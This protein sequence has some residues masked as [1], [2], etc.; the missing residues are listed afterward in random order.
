MSLDPFLLP[1]QKIT[2]HR[3]NGRYS[4]IV[5]SE[6]VLGGL[7]YRLNFDPQKKGHHP[8]RREIIDAFIKQLRAIQSHYSKV[9][10]FRFDLSVPEG[11]SVSQSNDLVS[12]LF[13]RLRGR[14]KKKAWNKQPIKKFAYG[15]VRERESAAQ[16]HYHCWIALPHFQVDTAGFRNSGM[17]GIISELW[18][19]LTSGIGRVHLPDGRYALKQGDHASLVDLVERLSYLAK[20]RGKVSLGEGQRIFSTSKLNM[21]QPN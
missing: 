18:E 4:L 6:Y 12:E 20:N 5:S 9:F 10:A 19:E 2:N 8:I 3:D 15:W 14:F 7:L 11:M 17:V 21:K 16:V 13:G 1:E